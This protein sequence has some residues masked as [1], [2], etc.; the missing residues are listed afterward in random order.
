MIG[1]GERRAKHASCS[2]FT[3]YTKQ[4]GASIDSKVSKNISRKIEE[5][6]VFM[7][8]V[9]R[10]TKSH[11]MGSRHPCETKIKGGAGDGKSGAGRKAGTLTQL[12]GI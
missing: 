4:A 12:H 3:G 8:G 1:K 2:Q 5:S 10:T 7:L 6:L 9:R 11:S